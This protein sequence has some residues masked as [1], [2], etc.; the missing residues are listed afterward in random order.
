MKIELI[1]FTGNRQNHQDWALEIIAETNFEQSF[2]DALFASG[3]ERKQMQPKGS[4]LF[5][6]ERG[7]SIMIE[8]E[9]FKD[10]QLAKEREKR[11]AHR[12]EE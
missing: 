1:G 8:A 2:F 9:D 7:I 5:K 4:L 11:L 12:D 10:S 6:S 3:V